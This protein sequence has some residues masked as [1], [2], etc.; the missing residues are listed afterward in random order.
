[1]KSRVN[2]AIGMGPHSAS[3]ASAKPAVHSI[4]AVASAKVPR[5]IAASDEPSIAAE[6]VAAE[7]EP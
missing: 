5:H 7:A 1:M 3:T 6:A 4:S 2:S